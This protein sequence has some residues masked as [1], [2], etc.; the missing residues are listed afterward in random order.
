MRL[1]AMFLFARST[2]L[3]EGKAKLWRLGFVA[4]KSNSTKIDFLPGPYYRTTFLTLIEETSISTTFHTYSGGV[5]DLQ[6][7][8]PSSGLFHLT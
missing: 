8:C 1:E 6:R 5:I 3:K 4:E 7:S 2:F